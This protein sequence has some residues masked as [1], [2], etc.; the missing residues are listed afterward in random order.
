M[1]ALLLA[2]CAH[3]AHTATPETFVRMERTGCQG[4]CLVYTLTLY[5][6]GAVQYHGVFNVPT[7][8]KWRTIPPER[9]ANLMDEAERVKA[10][11]CDPERVRRE[12]PGA[13]ITVSRAGKVTRRFEHNDGDP[14]APDETLTV[15]GAIDVDAHL[16]DVL[17][18]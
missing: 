14:C 12:L 6:D 1:F 13:I 8:T 2:A 10:W 16:T 11:H 5:A 15:E 7:G 9:V 4:P 17:A 3:A 18:K